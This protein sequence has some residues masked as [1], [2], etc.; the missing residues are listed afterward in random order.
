M[1]ADVN[2][3]MAKPMSNQITMTETEAFADVAGA[4]A[5]NRTYAME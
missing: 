1:A 3:P 2:T 5:L 4:A